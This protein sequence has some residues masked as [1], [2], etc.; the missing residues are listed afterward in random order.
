MVHL[1]WA[2]FISWFKHWDRLYWE[3]CFKL[4]KASLGIGCSSHVTDMLA[5]SW[6]EW[7]CEY[8]SILALSLEWAKLSAQKKKKEVFS[9]ATFIPVGR[10]F[11]WKKFMSDDG[12]LLSWS[13]LICFCSSCPRI[14]LWI[15]SPSS[16]V[17][18]F[19]GFWSPVR[20]QALTACAGRKGVCNV[21]LFLPTVLSKD[22]NG[23]QEWSFCWEKAVSQISH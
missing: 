13:H 19:P 3:P 12:H 6:S 8:C 5:S 1:F 18:L 2:P 4:N 22:L 23:S 16:C 17:G 7:L 11:P 21:G 10:N 14:K 15:L 20:V 9:L